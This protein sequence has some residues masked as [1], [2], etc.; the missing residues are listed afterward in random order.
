M[1]LVSRK[2]NYL[3]IKTIEFKETMIENQCE[4]D[5]GNHI[6]LVDVREWMDQ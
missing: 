1:Q 5:Q 6:Y 2:Y 3:H 4:E